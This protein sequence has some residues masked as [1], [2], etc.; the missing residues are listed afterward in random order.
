[1]NLNGILQKIIL[2]HYESVHDHNSMYKQMF[3]VSMGETSKEKVH[4]H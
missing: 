4:R 2:N 1:M 3:G